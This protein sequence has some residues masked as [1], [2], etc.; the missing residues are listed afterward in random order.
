MLKA[1]M[2]KVNSMQ[3]LGSFST[4]ENLKNQMEVLEKKT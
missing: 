4:D 3:N 1:L 2:K